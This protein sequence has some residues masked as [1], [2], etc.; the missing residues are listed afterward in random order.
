MCTEQNELLQ[1]KEVSTHLDLETFEG[2]EN[3]SEA[4]FLLATGMINIREQELM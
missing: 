3:S 1:Y 2:F 4:L